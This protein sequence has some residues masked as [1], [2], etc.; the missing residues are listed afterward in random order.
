M[1][2]KCKVVTGIAMLILG[3]S[4]PA[5]M[6]RIPGGTFMM[7]SFEKEIYSQ[8][9]EIPRHSV[10]VSGFS[11]RKYEVTQR[12]YQAVMGKNPSRV[13][14]DNRP[15]TGVSWYDAIEYCNA[16]SQREGL[17]PVGIITM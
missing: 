9:N 6:V 1:F 17:T 2:K 10:T 13:K 5:E 12:E 11:M 4:L 3:W 15:V 8:D 7:G 16:L 14:G